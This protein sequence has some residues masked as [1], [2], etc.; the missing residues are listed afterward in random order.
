MTKNNETQELGF[1]PLF[2]KEYRKNIDKDHILTQR[3]VDALTVFL[4]MYEKSKS[5][6]TATQW[7][8]IFATTFHETAF[9]FEP[10][11]E[12]FRYSEEWRKKNLRYF[13]YYGRGYTQLTWEENYRIFENILHLPL[14]KQPDLAM[15]SVVAFDITTTGFEKGI[16]TGKKI[17]DYINATKTDYIAA[18]RCINKTDRAQ[19]IAAYAAGF[20]KILKLNS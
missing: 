5:R 8:Y 15:T 11:R 1:L 17:S 10:V 18:R 12:A 19:T 7:A 13:P 20:E 9:T 4:T 16:F 2:F 3:E 14:V 6:F